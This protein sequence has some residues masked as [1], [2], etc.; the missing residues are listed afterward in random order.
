MVGVETFCW[1]SV[2]R[3]SVSE[4][5]L[6]FYVILGE[7]IELVFCDNWIIELNML[8]LGNEVMHI[9]RDFY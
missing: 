9:S 1:L 4:G 2:A 7:R 6:D 5:K 3:F 8:R